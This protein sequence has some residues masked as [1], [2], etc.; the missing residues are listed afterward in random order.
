MPVTFF[1]LCALLIKVVGRMVP[2]SGFIRRQS[3]PITFFIRYA[4]CALRFAKKR[5][6]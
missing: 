1:T 3:L 2:R 5:S 6:C 4:L